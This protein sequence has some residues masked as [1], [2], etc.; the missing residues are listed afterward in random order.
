MGEESR[1]DT[2]RIWYAA[3]DLERN[4]DWDKL[5]G[6]GTYGSWGLTRLKRQLRSL[7]YTVNNDATTLGKI[8]AAIESIENVQNNF[9]APTTD[10]T[11]RVAQCCKAIAV[12]YEDVEYNMMLDFTGKRNDWLYTHITG[13]AIKGYND[14]MNYWGHDVYARVEETVPE[15]AS[16][17]LREHRED[18]EG[19]VREVTEAAIL[20]VLTLGAGSVAEGGGFVVK[21]SKY[22]SEL[23]KTAL[24]YVVDKVV[25]NHTDERIQNLYSL[26]KSVKSL[27]GHRYGVEKADDNVS[28]YQNIKNNGVEGFEIKKF[29]FKDFEPKT[30]YEVMDEAKGIAEDLGDIVEN[31]IWQNDLEEGSGAGI[32]S[33]ID[34]AKSEE[35][36]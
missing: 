30:H 7:S 5:W 11:L 2:A 24:G 17:W 35:E 8:N 34:H 9:I 15:P 28:W 3:D 4:R 26:G 32:N 20:T 27:A 29:T 14:I 12:R 22:A 10:K 23:G 21:G 19:G 36:D 18:I 33:I 25:E 6:D 16:S 1:I 13:P 31:P